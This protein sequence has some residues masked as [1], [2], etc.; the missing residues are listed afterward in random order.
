MFVVVQQMEYRIG[1]QSNKL[2][3]LARTIETSTI[4]Y[5]SQKGHLQYTNLHIKY[6]F[7]LALK[8]SKHMTA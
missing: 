6:I 3:T 2:H 5:S 7:S 8:F 1:K 4:L